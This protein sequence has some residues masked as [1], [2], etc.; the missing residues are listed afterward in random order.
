MSSH[1]ETLPETL[2]L[3]APSEPANNRL[4]WFELVLVLVVCFGT[5]IIGS[6]DIAITGRS[7]SVQTTESRWVNSF[8]HEAV[9]LLLMGYVL[10]RRKV[11]LRSLGLRWSLRD[12][13]VGLGV[14]LVGSFVY[15]AGR[16]FLVLAV[17][18]FYSSQ[19]TGQIAHQLFGHPS[20]A[21]LPFFVINPF[22]E[23]LVV[24]AYLMTELKALTGSWILSTAVSV[25]VQ[26][27][28]HLYYGVGGAVV[29]SFLFMTFSIYYARARKATPIIFAHGIFDLFALIRIR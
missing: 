24:R 15:G 14:F 17:P 28:Y 19:H 10:A 6:L 3:E 9:G 12:L 25:L 2:P 22:F 1:L 11:G 27:S 13:G 7:P 29:L 8:V 23:E 21:A 16:S 5:S 18:G 20:L 4:R 26:S